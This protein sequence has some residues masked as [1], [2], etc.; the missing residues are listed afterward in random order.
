ME[1]K[2][3]YEISD[4]ELNGR[5][6]AQRSQR[7]IPVSNALKEFDRAVEKFLRTLGVNP[8]LEESIGWQMEQLGIVRWE[9]TDEKTPQ[10]WGWFFA[11]MKKPLIMVT[12][13]PNEFELEPVGW[14]S[15]PKMRK[16]GSA[17]CEVQDWRKG[18]LTESQGVKIVK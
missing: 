1:E 2:K 15:A 4:D 13:D 9:N 3:W 6:M 17:Y 10:L 14:I 18:T 16:D 11:V 12:M 7:I 5:M 8:D